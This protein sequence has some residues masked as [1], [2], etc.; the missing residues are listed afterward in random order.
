MDQQASYLTPLDPYDNPLVMSLKEFVEHPMSKELLHNGQA[1][2][3]CVWGVVVLL[4]N[5]QAIQVCGVVVK[6][7]GRVL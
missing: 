7:S 6:Q 1:F 5:G 4:H 3:V 2:Q